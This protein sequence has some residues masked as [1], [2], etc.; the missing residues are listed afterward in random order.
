MKKLLLS[1]LTIVVLSIQTNAQDSTG[2]VAANQSYSPT[3]NDMYANIPTP[4]GSNLRLTGDWTI[5]AWINILNTNAEI[6][7]I[8]T[9]SNGNTG[10]F[11]IRLINNKLRALQITNPSTNLS[12]VTGAT[13][14][15]LGV[16]NHIAATLNETTQELKVYVNGQLDGTIS[17]SLTTLNLNSVLRIGTRGDSPFTRGETIMDEVKIWNKAKTEAEIQAQMSGCFYGNEIDLLAWYNF[18]SISTNSLIDKTMNGN[19]GTFIQYDTNS[20]TG[21]AYYCANA[22]VSVN[23]VKKNIEMNIY[24]NP[25]Q[26]VLTISSNEAINELFIYSI[27][28]SLIKKEMLNNNQIDISSLEKGMYF[29]LINSENGVYKEKFI[30]E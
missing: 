7:L 22:T 25:A 12:I 9:Y 2:F 26:D 18:E 14:L 15:N 13:A 3:N 24:P 30:K 16:W 4:S 11:A 5:E 21:G 27:G 1:I 20:F 28:G 19:D 8:E 10:G 23:E 17:T 29:L 6:N